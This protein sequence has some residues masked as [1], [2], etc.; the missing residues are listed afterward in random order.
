MPEIS[1]FYGLIIL[2]NYLDHAP[3]HFHVW[4]GDFKAIVTINDNIVKGE[5]PG[6]ALKLVFEWMEIHKNELLNDWKLAQSGKTLIR[7]E[8]LN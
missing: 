8:P 1:R 2:M 5:M 4:Y 7:I 3:P 6:R